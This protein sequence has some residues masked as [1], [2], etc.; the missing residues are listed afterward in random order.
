MVHHRQIE[1]CKSRENEKGI[2]TIS[3][4]KFGGRL[5][6]FHPLVAIENFFG[7][8]KRYIFKQKYLEILELR[9]GYIKEISQFHLLLAR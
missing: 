5:Q 9:A 2:R 7:N 8:F 3:F 6:K 4:L 1:R